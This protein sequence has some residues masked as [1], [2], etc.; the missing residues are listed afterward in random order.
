VG[1]RGRIPLASHEVGVTAAYGSQRFS[2][3]GDRAAGTPE[4]GL[5][6]PA[7]QRDLLPDVAY[8][9]LR[10]GLDAALRF[11]RVS[12]TGSTGYRHVLDA[13]ALASEAWFPRATASG[14]DAS[15][16]VGYEVAPRLDL[17]VGGELRLYAI[18]TGARA[19]DATLGRPIAEGAADRYLAGLLGL[20]WSVPGG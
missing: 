12:V 9:F 16:A 7:A 15:L 17:L 5:P 4:P 10:P 11:G 14:F 19:A 2:I 20:S 1:V 18:D 13:G 3:D 6:A 8:S